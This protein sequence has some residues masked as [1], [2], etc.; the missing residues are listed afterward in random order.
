MKEITKA[1]QHVKGG[2]KYM[3]IGSIGIFG[4]SIYYSDRIDG[5]NSSHLADVPT[6]KAALFRATNGKIV[7]INVNGIAR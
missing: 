2:A 6:E 5:F 7:R 1:K 3:L 4:P